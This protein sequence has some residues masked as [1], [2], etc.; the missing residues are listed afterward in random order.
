MKVTKFHRVLSFSQSPWMKPYIDYNTE[1][2]KLAINEFEQDFYKLMNNSVFGKTMENIR[3][4]TRAKI[5]LNEKQASKAIRSPLYKN[6]PTMFD[7]D[8]GFFE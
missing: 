3:T 2:R 8:Y 4:Y 7:D 6:R 1:Q 5:Y